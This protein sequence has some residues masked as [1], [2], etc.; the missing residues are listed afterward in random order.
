M[1]SLDNPDAAPFD[2]PSKG[3]Y[4]DAHRHFDPIRKQANEFGRLLR[5]EFKTIERTFNK[6]KYQ[7]IRAIDM[8]YTVSLPDGS[9]KVCDEMHDF[10][11]R[12]DFT[13][14]Q[15]LDSMLANKQK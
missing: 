9:T 6:E 5:L 13:D 10:V 3:N 7:L 2:C 1:R 12:Q 4:I 11:E 8:T 14:L 15:S